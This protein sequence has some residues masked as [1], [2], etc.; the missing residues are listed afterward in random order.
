VLL[1]DIPAE[2]EA[3]WTADGRPLTA[4]FARERLA[5]M[6]CA[7]AHELSAEDALSAAVCVR[8]AQLSQL[9]AA[10]RRVLTARRLATHCFILSGSGEFL[11]R[12]LIE[13]GAVAMTVVSLAA[14]LG[15][16]ASRCAAAHALA[17]LAERHE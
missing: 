6:I 8:D 11:A 5:R 1:G 14:R 17:V 3:T 9:R 4:E 2:P 12:R 10:I 7:D 16:T 13:D 15:E